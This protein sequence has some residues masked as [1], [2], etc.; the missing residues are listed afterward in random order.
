MQKLS[1]R[2]RLRALRRRAGLSTVDL[3]LVL[4]CCGDAV[5]RWEALNP[6]WQTEP[7]GRLGVALQRWSRGRGDEITPGDWRPETER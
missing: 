5:R 3:G 6:S 4:G 7:S 1:P 2:I